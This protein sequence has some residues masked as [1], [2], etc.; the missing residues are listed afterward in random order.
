MQPKN[1]PIL[2]MIIIL[3]SLAGCQSAP[4]GDQTGTLQIN[5]TWQTEVWKPG[6]IG[7]ITLPDTDIQVHKILSTETF[8]N[9]V[10]DLLGVY[11][12]ESMPVGWYWVEASHHPEGVKET[13]YGKH[14]VAHLVQV[15]AGKEV[16]LDFRFENAGGWK[17][18]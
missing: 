10:T 13:D 5:V 15:Q 7:V 8:R 4:G 2:W 17:I 18:K 16:V 9:G 14:W 11:R 3:F 12:D 1:K 6:T